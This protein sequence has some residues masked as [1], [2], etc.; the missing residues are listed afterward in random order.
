[1]GGTAMAR[2]LHL[3]AVFP[4]IVDTFHQRPFPP[5]KL[6]E[7][8]HQLVFPMA[9]ELGDQRQPFRPQLLEQLRAPVAAIAEP[10]APE[11]ADQFANRW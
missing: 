4:W 11:W 7:D 6:V 9:F 10:F 1:M 3:A 5:Q 2:V 8:R